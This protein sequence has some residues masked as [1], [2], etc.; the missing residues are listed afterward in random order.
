M[1]LTIL[2]CLASPMTWIVI[3]MTIAG[4]QSFVRHPARKPENTARIVNSTPTSPDL[5]AALMFLSIAYRP[6]HAFTAK[7]QIV[8]HEDQDDDDQGGPDTPQRHLM[9]QLRRVRRGEPVDTLVWRLE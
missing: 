3:L 2:L 7:A 9:R 8:E 6:N 4:G 5:G 1:A